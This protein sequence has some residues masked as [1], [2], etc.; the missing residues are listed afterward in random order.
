MIIRVIIRNVVEVL[1]F[2][3]VALGIYAAGAELWQLFIAGAM[4]GIFG[5]LLNWDEEK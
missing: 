1:F 2:A 3:A 4:L 5:I